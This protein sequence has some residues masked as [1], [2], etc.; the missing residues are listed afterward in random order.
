MRSI[1][2]TCSAASPKM[3]R[4][5]ANWSSRSSSTRLESNRIAFVMDVRSQMIDVQHLID[6][7]VGQQRVGLRDDQPVV[8]IAQPQRAGAEVA[9]ALAEPEEMRG[10]GE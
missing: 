3:P 2:S 6:Q 9:Q 5:T 10:P 7:V 1:S 8:F 4:L